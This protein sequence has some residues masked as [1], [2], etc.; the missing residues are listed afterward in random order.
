MS[1]PSM[2]TGR[3]S[4]E[5]WD[6][7]ERNAD[8]MTPEQISI[9][10][11]RDI[12]PIQKHL[13]KIGKNL[14]KKEDF[15]LHAA[16]DLQARPYWKELQLQFTEDELEL[17]VY[18]W[19]QTVAQFKMDVMPTEELQ[20]IDAVKLEVL[21]NRALKEQK[22]CIDKARETERTLVDLK[23]IPREAIDDYAEFKEQ[24]FE[25]E[26]QLSLSRMAK[27]AISKDHKELLDKKG[28]ILKDLKATRDMRIE[29]IESN[30]QT[31][32]VLVNKILKDPEFKERVSLEMEKMRLAVIKEKERL[33]DYHQF[34]DEVDRCLLTP[35]TV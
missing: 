26:K 10:L 25:L 32:D 24:I 20:I 5:E 22:D 34:S 1:K 12:D 3:L 11:N 4:K 16:Y 29:R 15:Q 28:K 13:T 33:A 31:F 27:E 30:K 9:A 35:D 14:N 17:F 2:K 18:H 7:I 23:R 6:F 19:S 8:V 21:M